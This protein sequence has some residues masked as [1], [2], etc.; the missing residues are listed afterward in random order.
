M[1]VGGGGVGVRA[2]VGLGLGLGLGGGLGRGLGLGLGLCVCH[3]SLL[4]PMIVAQMSLTPHTMRVRG[5]S[6]Q[7]MPPSPRHTPTKRRH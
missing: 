6:T 7:H 4:C 2:W 3:F 5:E 1:C